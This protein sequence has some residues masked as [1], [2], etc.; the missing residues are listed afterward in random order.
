MDSPTARVN[1]NWPYHENCALAS[2]GLLA[3]RR[4]CEATLLA[5][6]MYTT[7]QNL[8]PVLK[9]L[10]QSKYRKDMWHYHFVINTG[11]L[12]TFSNNAEVAVRGAYDSHLSRL[13]TKPTKWHVR[14]AKTQISLCI[15]PVWSES[16]L[17]AWR[18]LGSSA[19][20][21]AHSE[22]SDQTGRMP[23]LICSDQTGRTPRLIW[24]F[25]GRTCH[26]VGFLMRRLICRLY[27]LMTCSAQR[28]QYLKIC[29]F[30]TSND[31]QTYQRRLIFYVKTWMIYQLCY[32]FVSS[33]YYMKTPISNEPRHDKTCFCHMRTTKSQISLRIRWAGQFESYLVA[34]PEDRFSREVAQVIKRNGSYATVE[35]G[36]CIGRCLANWP[37]FSKLTDA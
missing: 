35:R 14:P 24:V 32:S 16:S 20:H 26:F 8:K 15:R 31:I 7:H 13:M 25:A 1:I 30:M 6:Y 23:R 29:M 5:R 12:Q 34:N 18:K 19:T 11:Y 2:C 37:M 10:W 17:S 9:V 3:F 22:D 33:K 4:S 21:W 28:F 27:S 36:T